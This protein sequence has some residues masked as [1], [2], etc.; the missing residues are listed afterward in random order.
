MSSPEA[1]LGKY[2]NTVAALAKEN[3]L[4]AIFIDEFIS[5]IYEI[6]EEKWYLRRIWIFSEID[7][8]ERKCICIKNPSHQTL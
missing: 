4:W 7:Q 2:R 8:Y 6:A 1:I 5:N 3:L